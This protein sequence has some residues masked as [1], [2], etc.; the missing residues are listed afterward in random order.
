MK[1]YIVTHLDGRGV[2]QDH[3]D[4]DQREEA[5]D[6]T[7]DALKYQRYQRDVTHLSVCDCCQAMGVEVT[8]VAH[9]FWCDHCRQ[10]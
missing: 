3:F 2:E 5:L 4:L 8:P 7:L 6:R 10:K 1:L 9:E